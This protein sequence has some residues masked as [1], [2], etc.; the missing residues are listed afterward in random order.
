MPIIDED[1]K[2]LCAFFE[3]RLCDDRCMAYENKLYREGEVATEEN[4]YGVCKR[5]KEDDKML[6]VPNNGSPMIVENYKTNDD[7]RFEE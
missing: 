1:N 3:N 6:Y 7:C 5:L 4:V 2:K